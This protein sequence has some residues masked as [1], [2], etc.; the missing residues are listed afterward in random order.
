MNSLIKSCFLLKI[1]YKNN[2]L[3]NQ[4][5]QRIDYSY[6]I[7]QFILVT[8]WPIVVSSYLEDNGTGSAYSD[9]NNNLKVS[10][11]IILEDS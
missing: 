7:S 1:D 11:C 2:L 8:M 3:V 10:S 6:K 5:P 9:Q 4:A